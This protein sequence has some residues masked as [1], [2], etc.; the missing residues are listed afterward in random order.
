MIG[1]KRIADSLYDVHTNAY[2][3]GM[4]ADALLLSAKSRG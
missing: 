3:A 2:I 4:A 1:W